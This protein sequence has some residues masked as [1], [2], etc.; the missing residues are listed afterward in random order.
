M[1]S[2]STLL[3]PCSVPKQ[4]TWICSLTCKKCSRNTR[5]IIR[6]SSEQPRRFIS[7]R[8]F[9]LEPC[10]C[11]HE[12]YAISGP[13]WGSESDC[14]GCTLVIF[15]TSIRCWSCGGMRLATFLNG[16][17]GRDACNQCKYPVDS[18]WTHC[19]NV[20]CFESG[21]FASSHRVF[22]VSY[23]QRWEMMKSGWTDEPAVESVEHVPL[24][25]VHP[26]PLRR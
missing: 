23:G 4:S 15:A 7:I 16:Y 5:T 8:R 14:D 3:I 10:A 26:T 2:S 20:S 19:W 21:E 18:S 22:G 12:H 25:P 9:L 17:P 1:D 24:N 11:G 6:E 13:P